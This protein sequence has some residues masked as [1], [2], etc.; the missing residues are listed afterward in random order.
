M[1]VYVGC[2]DNA[3]YDQVLEEFIVPPLPKG[4]F[5]RGK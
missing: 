3:E 2:A 1:V 4:I 5:K